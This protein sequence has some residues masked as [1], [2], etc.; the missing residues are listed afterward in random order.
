MERTISPMNIL[1]IVNPLNS[2]IVVGGF[3]GFMIGY[4]IRKII[5]VILFAL[6]GVLLLIMYL[7]YQGLISVN[8]YKVQNFTYTLINF[9]ANFTTNIL[10]YQ[11]NNFT[12]TPFWIP[13]LTIPFAGSMAVGI[14]A[15]FT[16]G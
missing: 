13:D 15:G 3:A 11:G 2:T 12:I 8:V 1:E 10:S 16:R 7:Q 6:G 14:T 4:F 9:I 5:K